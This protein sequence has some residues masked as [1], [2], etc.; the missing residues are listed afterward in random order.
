MGTVRDVVTVN[1]TTFNDQRARIL[2][3]ME[4]WEGS[5]G[6]DVTLVANGGG[7]GALF[8][9][10]PTPKE[11]Y[12]TLGGAW[13]ADSRAAAEENRSALMNLLPVGQE[14]VVE[15]FGRQVYA[16][17]YDA[18]EPDLITPR[19]FRWS[20]PLVC[21]DPLRYFPGSLGGTAGAWTGVGA[22]RNY[23][24][25][26]SRTYTADAR[27]YSVPAGAANEVRITSPGNATSRRVRITVTGP[28]PQGDWRV[29]ND[30]NGETVYTTASLAAGQV[31]TFDGATDTADQNG[32]DVTWAMYGTIPGLAPGDNV[33][34]LVTTDPTA[35]GTLS[36]T[37]YAAER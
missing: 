4:G 35:A 22:F 15:R 6:L 20:A 21:L 28:M 29:V 2:D 31:V 5:S 33:F 12:L 17:V 13:V 7:P 30:A 10:T 9:T 14:I 36:V 24:A 27:T 25:A 37:A 11:R 8:G 3:V 32:A 1:G 26:D 18:V 16:W 23:P 19:G 34:R